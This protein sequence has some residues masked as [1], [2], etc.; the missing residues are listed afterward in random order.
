MDAGWLNAPF[1]LNGRRVWVAGHKGMVGSALVRRLARES[2]E[3][4]ES[5]IDLCRQQDVEQWIFEYRPEVVVIAAARVGGILA[6]RDYPADFLYDNLMIA[7]NIIHAAAKAGVSKLLFLGSS[8]IYPVDAEQPISEDALLGGKLEPT[9]EA[10]AVAKIAGVK[11]CQT[12]RA[13]FGHDYISVMPCNLYGPGD[14]FDLARSH[15]IPALIM[16]AHEAKMRRAQNFTVW[17]SGQPLREFLHVDDL[18]DALV[19]SLAHYS[20]LRPLNIGSAQEISIGALAQSVAQAVGF[21][22]GV[23]FDA[24][25]PDGAARKVMNSARIREAGWQP[26]IP[27]AQGLA[28]AY[29]AF[30]VCYVG[31]GVDARSVA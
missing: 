6:N 22:G 15:V 12:Y 28:Q 11:L 8:C 13:Q 1:A 9:N 5:E 26:Q 23:V 3:I 24:D 17:G 20:D 16:K 21:E 29:E 30:L 7:S 2:C 4:L 10:Y 25:K 14:R 18:A 27:L 31:D 19:F